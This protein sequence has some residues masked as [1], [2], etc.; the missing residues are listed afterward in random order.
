MMPKQFIG[1]RAELGEEHRINGTKNY[2]A[3]IILAAARDDL[4]ENSKEVIQQLRPWHSGGNH[5]WAELRLFRAVKHF[6]NEFGMEIPE[7]IRN[8]RMAWGRSF[9]QS[10][11]IWST[12]R[13]NFS[14]KRDH[15]RSL[16]ATKDQLRLG[17]NPYT[18]AEPELF[19]LIE[20]ALKAPACDRRWNNTLKGRRKEITRALRDYQK[21]MSAWAAAMDRPGEF[22]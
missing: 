18:P 3:C 7:I 2:L 4:L 21:A 12:G 19:E 15:I 8:P 11:T 5:A 17:Q 1:D 16:R 6:G 14:S 13:G 10:V 20:Q 9:L 22:G